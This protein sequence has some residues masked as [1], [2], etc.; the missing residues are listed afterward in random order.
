MKFSL[1]LFITGLL[2]AGSCASGKELSLSVNVKPNP[3]KVNSRTKISA[4]LLNTDKSTQNKIKKYRPRKTFSAKET[5]SGTGGRMISAPVVDLK[6]DYVVWIRAYGGGGELHAY[7]AGKRILR[8]WVNFH[9]HDHWTWV[10][11]GVF[12]P[13]KY[14]QLSII[15]STTHVK[16]KMVKALDYMVISKDINALP[17]NDGFNVSAISPEDALHTTFKFN[18]QTRRYMWIKGIPGSKNNMECKKA[19]NG[20]CSNRLGFIFPKTKTESILWLRGLGGGGELHAYKAGKRVVRK[21]VNFNAGSR[22]RWI[23]IGVYKPGSY[24]KIIFFVPNC[25]KNKKLTRGIDC[26]LLTLQADFKPNDDIKGASNVFYWQPGDSSVGKHNFLLSAESASGKL[27]KKVVIKVVPEDD[28]AIKKKLKNNSYIKFIPFGT[29]SNLTINPKSKKLKILGID[30]SESS[31]L[32]SG[33]KTKPGAE[34]VFIGVW[35][36]VSAAELKH[37]DVTVPQADHSVTEPAQLPPSA[38]IP[39]NAKYA[40]LYFYHTIKGAGEVS[41]TLFNYIIK[42]NNGKLIQI[43][44]REGDRIAGQLKPQDISQGKLIYSSVVQNRSVNIFETV[45]Q[46]PNPDLTIASIQIKAFKQKV[47]PVLLGIGGTAD[48][49]SQTQLK[50]TLPKPSVTINFLNRVRPVRNGLFAV[51]T[52]YIFRSQHQLYFD[53]F[54]QMKF[55]EVRIWNNV[56]PEKKGAVIDKAKLDKNDLSVKRL[57]SGTKTT[58]MLNLFGDIPKWIREDA[59]P[60]QHIKFYV[61]WYIGILEYCIETLHWPISSVEL[62]NERLIG[63]KKKTNLL[64]Y[65]YFNALA[66]QIKQRYPKI[67]IGGTAECWPDLRIIDQFIKYCNKNLDMLTWHIYATGKTSTPT[68]ALMEKTKFIADVSVSIEKILK[69]H[70]PNRKIGQAITEFNINYAAWRPPVDLRQS[71]G[72]G[73]VWLLSVLRN[74]LYIGNVDT[75]MIWHYWAGSTYGLVSGDKQLRPNGT[76]YFLLNKYLTDAMLLRASS[77]NSQI[78]A[79]AADGKDYYI[80]AVINK[81]DKAQE[82][83]CNLLNPPRVV[84]DD[85]TYPISNYKVGGE[86]NSFALSKT[87][88][89]IPKNKMIKLAKFSLI[90]ITIP[91]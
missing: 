56:K 23:K 27:I 49:V 77:N 11:L 60:D 72:D 61:D 51:N 19:I 9:A 1:S 34:K 37:R 83:E 2:L 18:G 32:P 62:F 36:K 53:L 12:K 69:K 47:I 16:G 85:F 29:N 66:A 91:K 45:W 87:Q 82:I 46:N 48:K 7:K 40:Q 52:P 70:V 74:L 89:I 50:Q 75:A 43:P 31:K 54:K 68:L 4:S 79:L 88:S 5:A 84:C 3:V 8:K 80:V 55:P 13:G 21:W 10:K 67:K 44:I 30:V 76:L 73:A 41:E 81:S 39:V 78:E 71:R 24:D 35:A 64:R 57:I 33:I 38:S 22:W 17:N 63:H 14:D 58:I 6:T 15:V 90:F 26:M 28:L 59:A 65:R 86:N 25:Y 42:Y 20:F